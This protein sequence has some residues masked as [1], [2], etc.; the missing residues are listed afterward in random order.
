MK[1]RTVYEAI[2][3]EQFDTKQDCV[4]YERVHFKKS[5]VESFLNSEACPYGKGTGP[6]TIAKTAVMAWI[7]FE[8]ANPEDGYAMNPEKVK[9]C[10]DTPEGEDCAECE[11]TE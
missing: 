1:E 3:G 7:E 8:G 5:Q 11:A 9:G 2:D 10:M 6:M 4:D